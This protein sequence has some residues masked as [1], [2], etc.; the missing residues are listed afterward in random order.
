MLMIVNMTGK[1]C[2]PEKNSSK[3][4]IHVAS[5]FL[6]EFKFCPTGGDHMWYPKTRNCS[7]C[8]VGS[9][10]GSRRKLDILLNRHHISVKLPSKYF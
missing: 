3:T 10:V 7:L 5:C 1:F 2:L 6:I 9:S 8:L 4:V